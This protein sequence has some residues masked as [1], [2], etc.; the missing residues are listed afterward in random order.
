M[1]CAIED[2]GFIIHPSIFLM[3]W[4]TGQGF[5]KATNPVKG[6]R[7]NRG[8][9]K[10]QHGEAISNDAMVSLSLEKRAYWRRYEL[11]LVGH[12]YGAQA[13][14]PAMEPII[15][16]Q[17]PYSDEGALQSIAQTG[18]GTLNI[19][20]ARL[21]TH[22]VIHDAP[23]G[24]LLSN[25][26]DANPGSVRRENELGRW[27]ANFVLVH[28]PGC[29]RLGSIVRRKVGGDVTGD[30]VGTPKTNKVFG[31]YKEARHWIA[32]GNEDGTETVE[33]WE[34]HDDCQVQHFGGDSRFYYQADWA[35]EVQENL[36]TAD[37]VRYE[38]KATSSE[39]E[40]G[41]DDRRA[42]AVNDGRTSSIDNPY[43]RGDTERLNIHPTVKPLALT[44]WLS[45]LLLPAHVFA[46]RRV[47]VP[48]AGVAS[49]MIGAVQAG[50]EEV[51]G[52]E[53]GKE[54]A[55]IG[56]SRLKYWTGRVVEENTTVV[57]DNQL[58]LF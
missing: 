38:Q 21:A 57:E 31:E 7:R 1:A 55:E 33:Y 16:F 34:C 46:P 19:D 17:K 15:I 42:K 9:V 51:T 52:V 58:R 35:A 44:R 6:A 48:F 14:K 56:R 5:P 26:P 41:L 53:L 54:Y 11:A 22:G 40:A 13:V 24:G 27:P 47:F 18:A 30:V 36:F 20:A 32:Y 10:G 12:R 43:Q 23:R 8:L 25:R 28:H 37:P 39:R 2:A 29:Q 3:G 4:V 50:W 49:E 45:S